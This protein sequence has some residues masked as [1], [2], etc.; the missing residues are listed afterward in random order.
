MVV[1]G[2]RS[3]LVLVLMTSSRESSHESGSKFFFC[4]FFSFFFRLHL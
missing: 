1:G 4:F 3:F 2:F